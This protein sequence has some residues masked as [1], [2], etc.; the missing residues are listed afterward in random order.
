VN[1]ISLKYRIAIVIFLLQLFLI[2]GVF[3]LTLALSFGSIEKQIAIKKQ[4]LLSTIGEISRIALIQGEYDNLQPYISK[5]TE[6][7]Q[8][9]LVRIY[10]WRNRIVA[11]TNRSEVGTPASFL[12]NRSD[13]LLLDETL[14]NKSGKLGGIFVKLTDASLRNDYRHIRNIG[15][16]YAL[17]GI[18]VS[19]FFGLF[20]G[21]ALTKR[22]KI[23]ERASQNVV[24]GN[25]DVSYVFPGN[26]EVARL[27]QSFSQMTLS[28]LKRSE[29]RN[30]AE[31]A[32]KISEEKFALAFRRAPLMMAFS[33]IEDGQF[34]DVNDQ[35]IATSGF[36]REEIVGKTFL[37]LG[38][39][40]T[41][42]REKY[43]PPIKQ[44]QW[45]SGVEVHFITKAGKTIS[46]LYSG[47]TVLL[48]EHHLLLSVF[49]DITERKQAEEI[50]N[51]RLE[52]LNFAAT[53]SLEELLVK[54]LD[55]VGEL[56]DSPIGF[57]HFLE[58]DQKTLALQAWSTRTATE[59]CKAEGKGSHYA[60]DQAGVWVD[61]IHQRRSVIHNDYP[62]LPHRKGLPAGHAEVFREMVVP[63]MRSGRIVAIIG[64]GN[65]VSDYNA[66]D[67]QIVSYLAD[68]AWEIVKRKLSEQD[69]KA[70]EERLHRAEK[71]EALGQL[72]G[73]VAHD[74]NNVLGI[75]TGYS[76]L[77]LME[78]P[79][80]SRSRDHV[81]KILKSTE[82]GA[83]IIQ[84]LL[85]L[86]RRGVIVSEVINLNRIVS[87]YLESPVFENIKGYYPRVTFTKDGDKSLLN[88]KGSSVHLE[89]TLMN[90]VSNAAEAISDEGQV[91]IRTENCYLDKPLRGYDEV[92]QGDYAVL[93]V[94]DTGMGIPAENR[95][96]I[97]EPFYTKKAMGRSGTG[98]GLAIVWGTIKDHNGYIDVQTESGKGTTFTLYFPITQEECIAPHQKEMMEQYLGK[99]ESVLVVDDIAEQRDVASSLLRRLGYDIHTVSSGEEAVE[100]LKINK[101]DILV[102]DMIMAPGIDG[103]ET[104]QKVLE[105]NPNQKAILVSGFSETDRVKEAQKLGA[106]AY[107]KKPYVMEKIGVAIRDE[108]LRVTT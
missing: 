100:Y 52:L 40:S 93:T 33:T 30:K 45:V 48:Q 47:D 104:Y 62:S 20:M 25:Y 107:V 88:I 66:R 11:S 53:H 31:E 63:V 12:N 108:L 106:G 54:T 72:A 74:L 19:A 81:D 101:A 51:I 58:A 59:F 103:M 44:G 102:I 37:E 68:V 87:D 92:K 46:C 27:S 64:V 55:K 24:N 32:L 95:E 56:V 39:T 98:L 86:A 22:L 18:T 29:E 71:M 50:V 23:L 78:I 57:Y 67:E 2:G 91:T 75:L 60:I 8:I 1:A 6:D 77:L 36:T 42:D 69:Q 4:V 76:E 35:F 80:G 83:A 9:V 89:K 38:V 34:L 15:L 61:C 14:A 16:I 73:G 97:F 90:L 82:K 96:K 5:L 21:A 3:W 99:G 13:H 65:K 41:E 79:E 7:K 43:L 84:D 85:T 49:L 28:L 105:I 94:S 70:L 26:D 10:D 17:L